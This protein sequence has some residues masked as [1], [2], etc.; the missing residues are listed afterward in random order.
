[1]KLLIVGGGGRE[2]ALAWK[3]SQSPVIDELFC[4]PGNAGIGE[5]AVC[6]DIEATDIASIIAFV[7]EQ[8]VDFVVVGP[9]QPLAMGIADEITKLG[10]PVFGPT[11]AA[12]ELES[13]KAYAKELMKRA[14]IPTAPYQVFDDSNAA[15]SF[16]ETM[17]GPWVVKADGLA[18]GKGVLICMTLDEAKAAIDDVLEKRIFNDAGI[19]I[20]I[21]EFLDGEEL[22]IMAFCD[23]KTVL[24]MASAQDHKRIFD[25]DKGL[26]TGGMGAYSPAPIATPEVVDD[27]KRRILEP[28]VEELN[29][30]GRIFKGVL[31]AGL[32]LTK[33]GPMV[34]EFNV[35]FG[36]PETQVVLPRLKTD[37]FEIMKA[38]TET[39]LD[40]M[41]ISWL[42]DSCVSVVM[43]SEGYPGAYRKGDEITGLDNMPSEILIFHSG[44]T[45]DGS[46]RILTNGGRVLAATALGKTIE[47]AVETVYDGVRKISFAG[48]HYR[49]DIAKR[50]LRID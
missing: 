45:Q 3:L 16:A 22:S 8:K 14:G 11:S 12:A 15:K 48:A 41:E 10:V 27:V 19:K 36:D 23:G 6:L 29:K 5:L 49:N 47:S 42:P 38:V 44:T 32:M 21:E 13:S 46:G 37:L 31:Y 35:R 7:K 17:K 43:A 2:H 28:I 20:V 40:E 50:G 34:I 25:G 30:D 4:A 26:N 18:A 1:M 39:R 9:E 33:N 24:P